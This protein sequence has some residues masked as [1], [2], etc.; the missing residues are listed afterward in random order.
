[1]WFQS[2]D[3]RCPTLHNTSLI[4]FQSGSS[5]VFFNHLKNLRC[6]RTRLSVDRTFIAL[7]PRFPPR[8]VNF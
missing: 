8:R 1:M 4:K 5:G 6:T 7:F 3:L 2:L